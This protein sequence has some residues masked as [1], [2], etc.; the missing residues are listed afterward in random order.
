LAFGHVAQFRPRSGDYAK[1]LVSYHDADIRICM[2]ELHGL[3]EDRSRLLLSRAYLRA[4][5]PVDALAALNAIV[6]TTSPLRDAERETLRVAAQTRLGDMRAMGDA[7]AT[8]RA[9]SIGS[10][11]VAQRAEFEY[12]VGLAGLA[13]GDLELV[14]DSACAILEMQPHADADLYT[15]PLGH[16][17]A[18]AYELL[19]IIDVSTGRF[20]PANSL[21]AL[22]EV[23]ASGQ[24]DA[25]ISSTSL[26]TVA[27]FACD[28]DLRYLIDDLVKRFYSTKWTDLSHGRR[29]L[30]TLGLAWCAALRGEDISA[31]RWFRLA[32]ED[33]RSPIDKI[34]IAVERGRL[35]AEL[36]PTSAAAVEELRYAVELARTVD[37]P[38]FGERHGVLVTLAIAA[39]R[40]APADARWAL[41]RYRSVRGSQRDLGSADPRMAVEISFAE[42]RLARCEGREAAA[43]AHLRE[44]FSTAER[45]GFRWRAQGAAIELAELR[46]GDHF[47][48]FARLEAIQRPTSWLGY[49]TAALS[50]AA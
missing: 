33:A 8:A 9:Y 17:R 42:G 27:G 20:N 25:W 7:I 30:I 26:Q 2:N 43:I 39:A 47:A 31:F 11:S 16:T 44:A 10:P 23:D 15:I 28:L 35:A 6:R 13:T 37:W 1:A 21:A 4:G 48:T 50:R 36:T 5:Q 49:R 22:S 12:F 29:H 34:E 3:D 40:Q 24:P 45:I 14:E 18:R 41:E 19:Q 32:A 46:A 38:T